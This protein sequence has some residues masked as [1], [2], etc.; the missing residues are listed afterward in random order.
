VIY[1]PVVKNE[2]LI[3]FHTHLW[4]LAAPTAIREA[5]SPYYHPDQWMPHISLAYMDVNLD[6]IGRVMTHLAFKSF[7]WEMEV[8]N[9]AFISEPAGTIG[10]LK[11]KY[12]FSAS[13][14]IA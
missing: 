3:N 5:P 1:I 4:E 12:K 14:Q 11:F 6:N 7:S 13:E 10:Q 8:N 9:L 2:V